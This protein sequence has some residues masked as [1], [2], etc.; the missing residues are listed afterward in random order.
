MKVRKFNETNEYNFT[1][2]EIDIILTESEKI[3]F[4]P[5]KFLV[6]DKGFDRSKVTSVINLE[7]IRTGN[8]I[9]VEKW[10]TKYF[11]LEKDNF[12]DI[13]FTLL[14]KDMADR[15]YVDNYDPS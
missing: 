4:K 8:Y 9:S 13:L 10:R 2:R 6:K 12:A 14:Y 15:D 1:E 7:H 11:D 3:G 5:M